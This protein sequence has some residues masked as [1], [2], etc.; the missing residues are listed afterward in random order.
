MFNDIPSEWNGGEVRRYG[1]ETCQ[2]VATPVYRHHK[3][4]N[5]FQ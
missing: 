1:K 3:D 2:L 4:K 5:V